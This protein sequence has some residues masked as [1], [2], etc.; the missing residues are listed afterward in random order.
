MTSSKEIPKIQRIIAVL[1]PSFL[2]AGLAT[3][4]FFTAFDPQLLMQVS[5]YGHISRL[6][7]YT[8][9]FFLFWIL[10]AST[11]ALTCYFQKPCH[12][13]DD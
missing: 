1:W 7:G 9:G 10:T 11:C 8:I 13:T 4:L 2:T 6:G 12:K 5:G 3:I